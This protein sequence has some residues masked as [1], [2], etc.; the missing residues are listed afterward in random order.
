MKMVQTF[1]SGKRSMMNEGFG[2]LHP[3]NHLMAWALS[4]LKLKDQGLPVV[5][6]TD[7]EGCDILVNKLQLPYSDVIVK[8]DDLPCQSCQ[9]AYAKVRTYSLQKEPFIHVDSDIF[10]SQP[11]TRSILE[12]GLVVQNK[13][14]GTSY[15][16]QMADSL[17]SRPVKIADYFEKKLRKESISSYNMGIFGGHDLDFIDYY[18]HEVFRF[19][20]ENNMNDVAGPISN[21]EC[22]VIFEQMFFAILAEKEQHPVTSVLEREVNDK[23][24]TR[25]EFCDLQHDGKKPFFHIIGGHKQNKT[26]CDL[27]EKVLLRNYPDYFERI[28]SLFPSRILRLGQNKMSFVPKESCMKQ[29][30][31]FL[32]QTE[33]KWQGLSNK[34]LFIIEQ[35]ISHSLDFLNATEEERNKMPIRCHPYLSLFTIPTSWPFGAKKLFKTRLATESIKVFSDIAVFPSFIGPCIKEVAIDDLGFDILELAEKSI[36][37]ESLY[38]S[39]IPYFNRKMQN[40]SLELR[41]CVDKEMAYLLY[42]GAILAET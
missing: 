9:W 22:N 24:Y 16:K 35:G 28:L 37:Y 20:D 42:Q 13:E 23:G 10:L 8:Y 7:S 1:W 3:R 2:W 19:F 40:N 11:F 33:R 38:V 34:K 5:L 25:E 36:T 17:L 14:H 39:L 32:S 30:K 15:Y 29:Y 12:S 41:R 4:C 27:I 31:D 6:Y 21:V 18:C 26:I